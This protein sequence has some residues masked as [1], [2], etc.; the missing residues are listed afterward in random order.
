MESYLKINEGEKM[1]SR[2]YKEG[3]FF[4]AF[5]EDFKIT[6]VCHSVE[7]VNDFCSENPDSGVIHVNDDETIIVVAEN[8]PTKLIGV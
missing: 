4:K 5:G 3:D 2:N 7:A 6:C 8:E 1:A